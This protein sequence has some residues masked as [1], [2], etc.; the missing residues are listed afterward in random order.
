MKRFCRILFF[1]FAC[2]DIFAQ[3]N[4]KADSL[5]KLLSGKLPD[6]ARIETLLELAREVYLS[7]PKSAL[8]YCQEALV[9]AE[10]IHYERGISTSMGWIAYLYEQQGDIVNALEYYQKS[11]T[12]LEK[13]PESKSLATC[14]NNIA[15]IYKDQGE[16]EEALKIH[17]RSLGISNRIKDKPGIA[18][19]LNN[20]GLIYVGQGKIPQALDYYARALKIEEE[21]NRKDG[22][23][24]VLQNIGVVYR[25]Q[26]QYQTAKEYF[27]RSFAIAAEIDDKYSMGYILN[28]M[29]AIYEQLNIAD[30]AFHYYYHS[31]LLRKEISD[32]QGMAYSLK[33]LGLIS[34]K[35]NDKINALHNFNS[36]LSLFEE[37]GDKWGI[38]NICNYTGA[39]LIDLQDYGKAE[40]Y[41]NRSL[42]FA[43]E[44]GYPADIRNAAEKLQKI[45]RLRNEWKRALHMFDLYIDMRDSVQNEK[46]QK[47]SLKT[48]FQYEFEKKEAALKIEQE[49]K[50]SLAQAEIARQKILRNGFLAGFA[51]MLLFAAVFLYQRNK[52]SQEK[53]RSE[54]LLLNILPSETAEELKSTGQAKAKSYDTVTVMFTDFKNFTQVS[55]NMTAEELV[56]EIN[57]CYSEF[58]SIISRHGIE[59]IK[60]IGDSYMCAG[61]LPVSNTTNPIDVIKAA[62]EIIA[63]MENRN[64]KSP[65]EPKESYS[66]NSR[67]HFDIRIGIHTGSVIAG[68]VGIKKFAYDIWGDTVNIASRMESSGEAGKINISGTTYQLVKDHF[69]CS[70]RGK[71]QA[72]NKGEI[73]MYFVN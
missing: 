9:N 47:A 35:Q 66:T 28:S 63:F 44:L 58:D 40:I 59:K 61:G 18:N 38:A 45:Y 5:I 60:T 62:K 56:N 65:V 3:D 2:N 1:L 57:L 34:Q 52:I 54:E 17:Q 10:T 19:S 31:Y 8:Q 6:T 50:D 4:V 13:K 26:E 55:E 70:Y 24:T 16:I 73:D 15:A 72:K 71:V 11:L 30:S 20:V 43:K 12:L 29:G 46:N 36:S 42:H 67:I 49:K 48:Q 21:I 14:L 33:N 64:A 7:N 32:K 23:S 51:I 25:D 22:I 69:Q 68:I 37:L 27:Q 39:L 41:L 53:Q